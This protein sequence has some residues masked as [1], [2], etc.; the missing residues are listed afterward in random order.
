[1]G[2]SVCTLWKSKG[3]TGEQK[4]TDFSEALA[5]A[6]GAHAFKKKTAGE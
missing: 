5:F 6:R 4:P 2:K 1:M 3:G